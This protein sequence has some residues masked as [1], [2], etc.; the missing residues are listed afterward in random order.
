MNNTQSRP[1]IS[2]P[3]TLYNVKNPADVGSFCAEEYI[4]AARKR[5]H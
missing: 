3:L 4:G 5:A 1:S 2:R